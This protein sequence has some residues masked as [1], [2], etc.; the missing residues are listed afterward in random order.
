MHA[1][2]QSGL[3]A[4][5]AA[6]AVAGFGQGDASVGRLAAEALEEM[7]GGGESRPLL[8]L[9][10]GLTARSFVSGNVILANGKLEGAS[11]LAEGLLIGRNL[12][13]NFNTA[14]SADAAVI[15][16]TADW[17]R[18]AITVGGS[19]SI[20]DNKEKVQISINN[21]NITGALRCSGNAR[22][23]Q[24]SPNGDQINPRYWP[25]RN[26]HARQAFDECAG[27]LSPAHPPGADAKRPAPKR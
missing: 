5:R 19:L 11:V 4:A 18:D 6:R 12:D 14:A 8:L 24:L 21:T 13:V 9:G 16:C 1:L 20:R 15:L 17:C 22:P 10:S 27:F 23:V 26:V 25:R 7:G 2:F 3:R